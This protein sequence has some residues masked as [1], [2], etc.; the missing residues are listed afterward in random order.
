MVVSITILFALIHGGLLAAAWQAARRLEA[1]P[2]SPPAPSAWPPVRVVLPI[3][4]VSPSRQES[5]DDLADQ[6]YPGF[7]IQLACHVA[8]EPACEQVRGWVRYRAQRG[9]A[10]AE[11]VLAETARTCS[12]KNQNLLAAL[13]SPGPAERVLVFTDADYRRPPDWLRRLVAPIAEGQPA[14]SSGYYH[15]AAGRGWRA[16]LR[17]VSALLL[18]LTRQYAVLRQPWGGATALSRG[19]FDELKVADL[20]AS[21]VVDDVALAERLRAARIPVIGINAPA[22]LAPAMGAEDFAWGD[23]FTRQL[24]YLRAVQP[25]AWAGIGAGLLLMAVSL[26]WMAGLLMAGM[27]ISP[28]VWGL[29]VLDLALLTGM[30]LGLR[31]RH[32]RPGPRGRWL[33]AFFWFW[34]AAPICHLR[35]AFSR[36]IRWRGVR[37]RVGFGGRVLSTSATPIPP[38]ASTPREGRPRPE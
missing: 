3:A 28:A 27:R 30:G 15:A 24:A 18:F 11:L 16:A 33:A 2:P 23:W 31:A 38:P 35:T 36:T 8:D 37:Y 4:G 20:W 10:P 9:G 14:V 6:D 5:L 21:H 26:L 22:L 29:A 12:Q 32:P 25:G 34:L 13:G 7:E 17:P 19:L 1:A